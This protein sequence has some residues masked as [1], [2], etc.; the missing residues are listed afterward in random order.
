MFSIIILQL[1]RATSIKVNEI[2]QT[3]AEVF[4]VPN[5][6]LLGQCINLYLWAILE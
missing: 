1:L 4:S 6:I 5:K 2:F 3:N